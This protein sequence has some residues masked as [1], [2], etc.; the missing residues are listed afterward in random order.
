MNL[1]AYLFPSCW[2]TT[3]FWNPS[4]SN[5]SKWLGKIGLCVSGMHPVGTT[6]SPELFS[7]CSFDN[8]CAS[9][10]GPMF[11]WLCPCNFRRHKLETPDHYAIWQ[12]ACL[13]LTSR[14]SPPDCQNHN[15]SASSCLPESHVVTVSTHSLQSHV[16]SMHL[17][18]SHNVSVSMH[19]PQSRNVSVSMHLPQS[20]II[21][22]STHLPQIRSRRASV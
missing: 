20:H 8:L 5:A 11:L 15:A 4:M 9:V 6:L 17:P 1:L 14:Q 2:N 18:Q 10:A 12:A 19:L 13:R 3:T 16:V 7:T 22:S 21:S